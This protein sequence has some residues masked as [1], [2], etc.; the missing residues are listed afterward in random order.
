MQLLSNCRVHEV[1]TWHAAAVQYEDDAHAFLCVFLNWILVN[2]FRYKNL[3][4]MHACILQGNC[5]RL[6]INSTAARHAAVELAFRCILQRN[7]QQHKTNSTVW[8]I[9]GTQCMHGWSCTEVMWWP[10]KIFNPK[11]KDYNHLCWCHLLYL[12][13]VCF[14]HCVCFL[15]S[16]WL[17]CCS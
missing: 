12:Y 6:D 15:L 17:L 13:R 5:W 16:C 2:S 10:V 14:A 7:G 9:E 1:E 8:G 11:W 4:L 3:F